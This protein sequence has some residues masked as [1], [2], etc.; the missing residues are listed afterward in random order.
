MCHA[1]PPPMTLRKRSQDPIVLHRGVLRLHS[2]CHRNEYARESSAFCSW[3]QRLPPA[4]PALT[5][6]R[7]LM[8]C[9]RVP[10]LG[11]HEGAGLRAHSNTCYTESPTNA[12]ATNASAGKVRASEENDACQ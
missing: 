12:A 11:A 5:W 10:C 7:H 2:F 8:H 6:Q 9:T 3:E 1:L 4:H